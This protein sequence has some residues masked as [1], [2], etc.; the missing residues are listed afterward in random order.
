M[1]RDFSIAP[2]RALIVEDHGPLRELLAHTLENAGLT[3]AVAD[4]AD[5]AMRM[6]GQ[7]GP[8][9]V[10]LCD[11]RMPGCLDG[12]ELCRWVQHRYPTVNILVQTAYSQAG[13]GNFRYIQKPFSPEELITALRG[14][15]DDIRR[16]RWVAAPK[17]HA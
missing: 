10:L 8:I 2:L 4:S 12:L 1:N 15:L 11:I 17:Q 5:E 13:T 3:V 16:Q 6:L 14:N 9:D 7:G